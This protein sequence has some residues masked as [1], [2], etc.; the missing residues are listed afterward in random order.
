MSRLAKFVLAPIVALCALCYFYAP[1]RLA[2][3]VTLGR[4]PACP[5]SRAIHS[6]D[7]LRAQIAYK[8][9]IIHASKLLEKDP[10]GYHLW[11]TPH[12]RFW[13]PRGSDY[14]LPFN[15]AEQ[16]RKIYGVG[17]Q[18]VRA[19][20]IVLDCGANVGVYTREALKNGAKLVVSIEPAPENIECLRRNFASEIAAG[21]VILY[22]KGVW[23]KDET[24]VMR[25]DPNNSAAD[26]FIIRREGAVESKQ[27]PLTT[28]D[29][30]VAELKLER[31]DFIKMD[32]EG[33]EQRAL[34]GA[35]ETLAKY[36]PRMALAAYHIPSDPEQFPVLV[37]QAWPNYR[38]QCGPC[39]ETN[40]H[41]RPDVLY[42]Q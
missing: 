13:I 23:D 11:D 7:E 29:K 37:R 15:L 32:I 39:A 34:R 14:V 42:F 17:D 2:A 19:G 9:R 22:E 35:R 6:A 18:D 3:L 38:M 25:I 31:V 4:S 5:M 28:V 33:A 10:A 41:V 1:A 30:L 16:E 21:R 12:G 40:G 36:R 20:D 27:L 26:S 24:L 8:D